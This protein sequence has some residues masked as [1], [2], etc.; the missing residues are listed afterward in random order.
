[1]CV[2][3]W[4]DGWMCLDICVCW[5]GIVGPTSPRFHTRLTHSLTHSPTNP[6]THNH[7]YSSSSS[8]SSSQ[9]RRVRVQEGH[10]PRHSLTLNS[11]THS[12]THHHDHHQTT[13]T[14]QAG[15]STRRPSP[16]RSWRSWRRCPRRRTRPSSTCASSSRTASSRSSPPRWVGGWLID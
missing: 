4:M 6:P 16:R 1:V 2:D 10:H 9:I 14:N 8:S 13:I 5:E 15:S 11:L 3:G 12:L 7:S